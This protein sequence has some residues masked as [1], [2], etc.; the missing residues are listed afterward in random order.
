MNIHSLTVSVKTTKLLR[1]TEREE[2]LVM[3]DTLAR[4]GRLLE[5]RGLQVSR[6]RRSQSRRLIVKHL[7]SCIAC[8]PTN[9]RVKMHMILD[10][11]RFRNG[12]LVVVTGLNARNHG[13]LLW[14]TP[15]M[16]AVFRWDH[17][18]RLTLQDVLIEARDQPVRSLH[19]EPG[20][21]TSPI[22]S[23]TILPTHRIATTN[24]NLLLLQVLIGGGTPFHHIIRVGGS[25]AIFSDGVLHQARARSVLRLLA[26]V[27]ARR[28]FKGRLAAVLVGGE[29]PLLRAALL[30]LGD[31]IAG[32][33]LTQ[34]L[35]HTILVQLDICSVILLL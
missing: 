32:L 15:L 28:H 18:G 29:R 23:A 30:G 2:L 10:V 24:T 35:L 21:I 7:K 31:V 33:F 12:V 3:V 25:L 20:R 17:G 4:V 26:V 9:V 19:L 11:E 6:L 34:V 27:A 16:L 13:L 5:C 1:L 22:R 14:H 8:C